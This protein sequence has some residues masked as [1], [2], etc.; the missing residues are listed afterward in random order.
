M[1]TYDSNRKI[2]IPYGLGNA[3]AAVVDF[4]SGKYDLILFNNATKNTYIYKG[5]PDIGNGMYYELADFDAGDIPYGEY[6]YALI[7]NALSG[8]E[9]TA[10][11]SLLGTEVTY[12]G[13]T[14]KLEELT[15]EVGL[16]KYV[17]DDEEEPVYRDKDTEFYYRKKS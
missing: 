4:V 13:V 7:F 11:D 6:S 16:L 12:N 17:N 9:Y 14:Y 3:P 5:I 8:V 1:I 2:D 15:P 10:K